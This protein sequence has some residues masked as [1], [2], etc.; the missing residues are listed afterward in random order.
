MTYIGL[1]STRRGVTRAATALAQRAAA[2]VGTKR[3]LKD[4]RVVYECQAS[5]VVDGQ[6]CSRSRRLY[7]VEYR[8]MQDPS[9][10]RLRKATD[11]TAR[12]S[13]A[14][15]TCRRVEMKTRP[16]ARDVLHRW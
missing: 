13:L 6:L 3:I 2:K 7:N 5:D 1:V 9:N 14:V 11:Y 16:P 12:V 4:T 8:M 15:R 10:V